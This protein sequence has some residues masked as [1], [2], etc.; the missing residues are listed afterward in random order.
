M[1]SARWLNLPGAVLVLLLMSGSRA[2]AQ[3]PF[4]QGKT[5]RVIVGTVPGV[6]YD[7]WARLIANNMGKHIPGKPGFIVQNMPGAGHMIAAN[8]LY[9]VAKP[10]GLTLIGSVIPSLYFNQLIGR[11]EVQF[12]WSKFTWIGSP[13]RGDHQIYM[14]ADAPYKTLEDI[15][16]A[17]EP[18]RCGATGT[19][20]S[21]YYLPKLFEETLGLK[22]R[23]VVGYPGGSEIDLA[24]E[25][26]ELHCRAF[27]I[28]AFFGREPFHSWRKK[29][30]VRNLIQTGRKR[31]PRM[32]GVP[33]IYELMDEYKTPEQARRLASVVLAAGTLGRPMLGPPGIPAERVKILREAFQKTMKDPEFLAEVRQRKYELDPVS[34]EELEAL[35]KEVMAQPREV[36]ERLKKILGR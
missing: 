23:M 3:A 36:V 2:A 14:R 6:L 12:E 34:G 27:T 31:D 25:R 9:T 11:K 7:Q 18:P 33:T 21:E 5:I 35:V 1:G 30:F 10:D 4:Y 32:P 26:G 17:K 22:F 24:V 28:E 8:Y 13:V 20:T 29:G 15:R 16:N 19:G